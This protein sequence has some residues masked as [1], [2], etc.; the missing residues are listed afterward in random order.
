MMPEHR[1][2]PTNSPTVGIARRLATIASA[3]RGGLVLAACLIL[4]A[5]GSTL[6]QALPPD[7]IGAQAIGADQKARI[8]AFTAANLAK[9]KGEDKKAREDA[10]DE[11]IK[12]LDAQGVALAFRLAYGQ[13]LAGELGKLVTN[14]DDHV[15]FNALRVAS[16]LGTPQGIDIIRGGLSDQRASVRAGAARSMRE[17]IRS[18]V[19]AAQSPVNKSKLETG[20]DALATALNAEKDPIVARGLIQALDAPRA[21][22]PDAFGDLHARAMEKLGEA[23]AARLKAAPVSGEGA[24]AWSEAAV[25]GVDSVRRT[26]LDPQRAKFAGQ[27]GLKKQAAILSGQALS[28]VSAR[29]G[30]GAKSDAPDAGSLRSVTNA[31]E[32]TLILIDGGA[33]KQTLGDALS[34][35]LESGDAKAFTS[36]AQMWFE[37]LVVPPFGLD[38]KSFKR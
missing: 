12:P 3:R 10:R 18:V 9:L 28:Y 6:G 1:T 20:V 7:I 21:G 26:F 37:R 32:T 25:S 36:A 22:T 15:A 5:T 19:T 16:R 30:A 35:S 29:L 23:L 11:L 38:A 4:G 17:A 33:I 24:A 27:A 31:L 13:A 14:A 34:T 2:L 8:E